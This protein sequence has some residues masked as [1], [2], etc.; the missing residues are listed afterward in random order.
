KARKV[1][2]LPYSEQPSKKNVI[3]NDELRFEV[4]GGDDYKYAW[5]KPKENYDVECLV[6]TFKSER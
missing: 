1:V 3:W 6:P 4:F 5:R 2:P